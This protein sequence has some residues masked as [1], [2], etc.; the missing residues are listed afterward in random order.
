M[1]IKFSAMVIVLMFIVHTAKAISPLYQYEAL[2]GEAEL[3]NCCVLEYPTLELTF[4]QALNGYK[5]TALGEDIFTVSTFRISDTGLMEI[6]YNGHIELTKLSLPNSIDRISPTAFKRAGNLSE[7]NFPEQF[8]TIP[9]TDDA[10]VTV[11]IDQEEAFHTNVVLNGEVQA[12]ECFV[13]DGV[14]Y[15]RLADLAKA[16]GMHSECLG[17][18]AP[19][20]PE[21][22]TYSKYFNEKGTFS[23][24]LSDGCEVLRENLNNYEQPEYYLSAVQVSWFNSSSE[25]RLWRKDK[26]CITRKYC[27]VGYA[28]WFITGGRFESYYVDYEKGYVPVRVIAEALGYKVFWDAQKSIVI[29]EGTNNEAYMPAGKPRAAE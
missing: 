26:L 29:L 13:F 21:Q 12:M 11:S 18:G 10:N 6:P 14:S 9:K 1:K 20:P 23:Y 7:V 25:N 28:D 3:T 4:P 22:R 16:L 24:I 19:M 17:F 8:E 27:P 15:V 2:G 5:V